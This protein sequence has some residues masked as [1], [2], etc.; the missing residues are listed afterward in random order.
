MGEPM[1]LT[2][3]QLLAIL[4]N[5]RRQAGV[6]VSVLNAAMARRQ[7]TSPKRMAAFLA[8]IGHES[9]HLQYVREL[10]GARYLAKYDTG[11][12]AERLGNTPEADGD[13]AKYC[14]RGLI[15]VTGRTNYIKTSVG[16]FGDARLL[17][18]PELLEQPEWAAESAAY[19]WWAHE[20]NTL[21]DAD[22]F[23][24]ITRRINGGVNGLKERRAL[25]AKAREVL[26]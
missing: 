16:L 2:Q 3:T 6:F 1:L 17:D 20:L 22:R 4:P 15:Q 11:T 5:A 13:G 18:T 9:G 7:I 19:F 14:G 23:T 21:A 10:G 25:W 12:L 24:D 26:V 8:Q